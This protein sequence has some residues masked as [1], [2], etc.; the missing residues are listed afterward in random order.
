LRYVSEPSFDA[1]KPDLAI[2]GARRN[3][4]LGI[5]GVKQPPQPVLGLGA[6][7]D[8]GLAMID[9][10]LDLARLRSSNATGR[11]G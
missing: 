3:A 1:I 10:Q 2:Q 6:L 4:H 9:E 11:S 5:D 8:E 7:P